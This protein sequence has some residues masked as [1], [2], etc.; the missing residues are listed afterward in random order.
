MTVFAEFGATLCLAAFAA[1]LTR[2][3]TARRPSPALSD[4][5]ANVLYVCMFAAYLAIFGT[6]SVLRHD[7]FHSGGFDLGVFDQNIWNSL[8]GRPF[9]ASIIIEAKYTLGQHFSPLL[10]AMVPLYAI[11]DDVRALLLFQTLALAAAS[12]PIFQCARTRLGNGLALAIAAVFFLFPAL[13]YV[14]LFEFHEVSLAVPLLAFALCFM[15]QRRTWPLLICLGL[16]LLAKE[17]IGI[18]VAAFGAYMALAQRQR[19]LGFA[20]VVIGLGWTIATLL[21]VIPAFRDPLHGTTYQYVDRYLY[22]GATVPEILRNIVTRPDLV[23]GHLLT[24]AKA[25]FVLQLIVPLLALPLLGA[26]IAALALPTMLYLLIGDYSCQDSIRCQYSALIIPF[27]FFAAIVG[28]EGLN[29]WLARRGADRT[30]RAPLAVALIVAGVASYALQGPG[31]L[32]QHFDPVLYTRTPHTALGH[33]LIRQIPPDAPVIADSNLASHLTHRQFAYQTSVVPDL[34]KIDYLLADTTLRIHAETEWIW[35]DLLATPFY[36]TQ[37]QQDGYILK[38]RAAITVTQTSGA[39]YDRRITLLGSTLESPEPLTRGAPATLVLAWRAETRITQSYSAFIHLRDA[40]GRTW[41][42][43]DRAPANGWLSTARWQPGDLTNDRFTLALPAWMPP[44]RYELVTGWYDPATGVRLPAQDSAGNSTGN[45]VSLGF[46]T[47]GAA[48]APAATQPLPTVSAPR[49][50]MDELQLLGYQGE[51]AEATTG[52]ALTLGLLWRAPATPTV[53]FLA[54]LSLVGPGGAAVATDLRRPGGDGYPTNAWRAGEVILD[55]RRLVVPPQAPGGAYTLTVTVQSASGQA[56]STVPLA[57]LQVRA[58]DRTFT[59]PAISRP[60]SA[61]F[62][63]SIQFLGH[64]VAVTNGAAWITLHWKS[65]AP[66]SASYTAFVHLLGPDGRVVA[67][68]DSPPLDGARPT[69]G[70]L[71]GEVLTDRITIPLP[72]G[73]DPRALTIAAGLYDGATGVRLTD[74]AGADHLDLGAVAGP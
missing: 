18:A 2:L 8:H 11:W 3:W 9:Q 48:L 74:E 34:R 29:R 56:S 19:R 16:A 38:R 66:V 55:W 65:L 31:P 27:A 45:E 28:L 13:Q 41:A 6:L 7:S 50:D 51:V 68:H 39:V 72:A 33:E 58:I 10:I 35:R 5:T 71:T 73:A 14:N 37:V 64:D 42:Q 21:W 15:L 25:E 36:E 20:I 46:V 30:C 62:D 43:D 67:Q 32:A 1:A 23:L 24:A 4:R 47:V 60:G 59:A 52:N 49:A 44:G 57:T 53:D 22:L 54:A 69:T 70:W 61:I 63:K 17:E 26:E 40:Q 12:I